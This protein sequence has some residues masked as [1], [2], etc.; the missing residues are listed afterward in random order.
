MILSIWV[1]KTSHLETAFKV[2]WLFK[3]ARGGILLGERY[4]SPQS[5]QRVYESD[6]NFTPTSYS[7]RWH[8]GI[9][10]IIHQL[11]FSRETLGDLGARFVGV[12]FAIVDL[13]AG[14]VGFFTGHLS[15]IGNP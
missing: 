1:K 13:M 4:D 8:G 9:K 2:P 15:V 10:R 7:R 11:N 14:D 5:R 12:V 6:P 3:R